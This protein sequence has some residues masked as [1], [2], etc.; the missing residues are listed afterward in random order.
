MPRREWVNR[1]G[2]RYFPVIT[3]CRHAPRTD[4]KAGR[5]FRQWAENSR[6]RSQ[7]DR[8]VIAALAR[9]LTRHSGAGAPRANNSAA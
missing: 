1:R 5:L 8:A 6:V 4:A 7:A 3:M 2:D 9:L